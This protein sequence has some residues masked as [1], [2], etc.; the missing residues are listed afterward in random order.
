M[1][2][3]HG[4]EAHQASCS[5][6][7]T[8]LR[9]GMCR[10]AV[11]REAQRVVFDMPALLSAPPRLQAPRSNRRVLSDRR[12][13]DRAIQAISAGARLGVV[14]RLENGLPPADALERLY[15]AAASKQGT[16][17]RPSFNNPKGAEQKFA[18]PGRGLSGLYTVWLAVIPL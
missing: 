5:V 13:S 14:E 9:T 4:E 3:V 17:V 15:G 11:R 12:A 2:R 7:T 16:S 6:A 8:C 1:W 10:R 18:S